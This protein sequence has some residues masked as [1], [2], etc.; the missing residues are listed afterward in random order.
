MLGNHPGPVQRSASCY[1]YLAR[2]SRRGVRQPVKSFTVVHPGAPEA[3]KR[4]REPLFFVGPVGVC[5]APGQRRPKVV[6]L[7]LQAFGPLNLIWSDQS[8]GALLSQNDIEIA[9]HVP[10]GSCLA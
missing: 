5:L 10:Q 4:T 8:D 7:H 2:P 3:A 9:V 1:R 6:M